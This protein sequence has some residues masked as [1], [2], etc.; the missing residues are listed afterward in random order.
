[1]YVDRPSSR[2]WLVWCA[3]TFGILLLGIAIAG[4]QGSSAGAGWLI[5][6]G[7][8]ALLANFA[9]A[10]TT[11][12]YTEGDHAGWGRALA[13]LTGWP[14]IILAIV[15]VVI[16]IIVAYIFVAAV[17]AALSGDRR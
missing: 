6:I 15:A 14:M 2:F 10:V 17:A 7:I 12:G 8:A 16:A 3:G 13:Q 1:M 4:E 5:G 9:L 11:K